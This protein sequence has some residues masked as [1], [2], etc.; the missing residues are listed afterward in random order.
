[1]G[2]IRYDASDVQR[3]VDWLGSWNVPAAVRRRARE[4]VER[5]EPWL[6]REALFR[7][8][9]F[10]DE[11]P[12]RPPGPGDLS[13]ADVMKMIEAGQPLPLPA[14][15]EANDDAHRRARS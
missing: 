4:M 15:D 10:F 14:P 3:L 7:R 5:G 8:T 6:L 2:P 9:V 11:E 13:V 1:M 12:L